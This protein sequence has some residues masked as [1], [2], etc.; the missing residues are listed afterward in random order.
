MFDPTKEVPDLELCKRLKELGYPQNGGGWYWRLWKHQELVYIDASKG[1]MVYDIGDVNYYS[2]G[3][4]DLLE[5]YVK[6]PTVGELGEWFPTGCYTTRYH[7]DDWI[8]IRD[9]RYELDVDTRE[10]NARAKLLIW[11]VE[12]REVE[13]NKEGR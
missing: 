1:Y 9:G 13:F 11:L 10:A 8:A 4:E 2:I 6:A 7:A 5:D 3:L 12:N